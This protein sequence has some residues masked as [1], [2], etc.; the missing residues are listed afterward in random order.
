MATP[1]TNYRWVRQQSGEDCAAASLAIVIEHYRQ[2]TTI[3]RIRQV[4][5][6]GSGGTTFASLKRGAEALG[7]LARCVQAEPGLLDRLHEV[8]L[9]ALLYWK[10][11]HVLVLYGRKGDTFVVSDPAVGIRYLTREELLEGW[12]GRL[13][14]LLRPHPIRFWLQQNQHTS[15]YRQL[16]RRLAPHRAL[17]AGVA[18]LGGVAGAIG[19]GLPVGLQYFV[20]RVMLTGGAQQTAAFALAL[21]ALQL[22]HTAVLWA[23]SMLAD[24]LARSLAMALK[25]EFGQQLLNLPLSF[26]ESRSGA[27][28][29]TRLD[30]V[31]RVSSL[32]VAVAADLPLQVAV[33]FVGAGVLAVYDLRA[34]A[35][36]AV[37]AVV[38]AGAV[39][40][41][42]PVVRQS[43]YRRSTSLG[44]TLFLFAQFFSNAVTIRTLAAAPHLES[45]LFE[46]LAR[47]TDTER[48]SSRL[49]RSGWAVNHALSGLMVAGVVFV[50]ATHFLGG[51]LTLGQTIAVTG[52]SLTVLGAVTS[53]VLFAMER[54]EVRAATRFLEECFVATPENDSDGEKTWVKLPETGDVR[55]EHVSFQYAGRAPLL[56]DLSVRFPGGTVS[57]IV[58]RSGSGKTTLASLLAGLHRADAGTYFVGSQ[59]LSD[60]PRACLRSQVTLVPQEAR[61]LT[62]S[63]ADNVKL[64]APEASAE[65]VE[66][67]CR[68]AAAHDFV[69]AFPEGYATVLGDFSARLSAG[70]Q[71]RL[72]IARAMVVDPP[73]LI[74]DE[75]TSHLDPSTEAEVLDG[76]LRQRQGK[77]TILIS[78][79]PQVIQRASWVVRL[80][81]GQV[82]SAG[83]ADSN[84]PGFAGA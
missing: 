61:F 8:P 56:R 49:L 84:F 73:V 17:L 78:H 15:P 80:E 59:A 6:T 52:V 50:A 46:R 66:A 35:F 41:V 48:R 81:S 47:E 72:A 11:Y 16:L 67:A 79:R 43:S 75:S 27:L 22:A 64:G 57:A 13:T 54:A 28:V 21:G 38:T 34:L 55:C 4:V 18:A 60:L 2:P 65:A 19:L 23:R 3:D 10:G 20:D 14:L 37:G 30:E 53:I 39:A 26:H 31:I 1:M 74:L 32:V 5:A 44:E 62:R 40:A 76:V 29:R 12:Q 7:F 77:T 51:A 70:E 83:P 68:V 63:V 69:T 71:Q 9:P 82:V 45:E 24:R 36:L 33:V 58:G 42:V 25:T